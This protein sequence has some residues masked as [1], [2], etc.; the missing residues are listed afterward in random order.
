MI[1]SLNNL[2]LQNS[3]SVVDPSFTKNRIL[4]FTPVFR[5]NPLSKE[6][7]FL[8]L[9]FSHRYFLVNLCNFASLNNTPSGTITA[10]RPFSFKDCIINCR[11]KGSALV[12]SI[13]KSLILLHTFLYMIFFKPN[14]SLAN[15]TSTLSIN[16][17]SL[18]L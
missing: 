8:K 15:I 1:S 16:T 10:H 4:D 2:I 18:I 9:I 13:F 3:I 6:I 11:N 14:G 12:P 7:I 17:F 5:N